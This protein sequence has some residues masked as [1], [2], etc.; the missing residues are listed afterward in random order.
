MSTNFLKYI[1]PSNNEEMQ[2]IQPYDTRIDLECKEFLPEVYDTWSFIHKLSTDTTHFHEIYN[3][4]KYERSEI[5]QKY[6]FDQ[7][8]ILDDTIYKLSFT[9]HQ[10]IQSLEKI[11]QPTLDE[12]HNN[13]SINIYTPA[14][15][16][17]LQNQLNSLKLSFKR[18]LMKYNSDS[19][20]Y[21][22]NLKQ[23]IENS[24]EISRSTINKIKTLFNTDDDKSHIIS[25]IISQ[26]QIQ[27]QQQDL[28][29]QEK[30][31]ID[32]ETRL[33]SVRILKERVQQM[34]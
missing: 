15:I 4:Y 32:L 10:R 9:I 26:E 31:I 25:S 11:V 8:K 13:Q 30:Q 12:F 2:I 27:L 23:S 24:K 17:I 34:K 6:Y 1:F 29:E 14:Y 19:I 20:D 21:Q 33:E 5:Q 7:L 28:T 18:I 22:N 16:R 3:L